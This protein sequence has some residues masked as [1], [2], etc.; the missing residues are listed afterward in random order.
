MRRRRL[1]RIL[2]LPL[3]LWFVAYATDA[4]GID[5]CPMHSALAYQTA[6]AM[7]GMPGMD[8]MALAHAE[9]VGRAP[10]NAPAPDVPAP[11]HCTC[12]GACC[13]CA[14]ATLP[15]SGRMPVSAVVVAF[16]AAPIPRRDTPAPQTPR[17]L[18]PPSNGPPA[19]RTA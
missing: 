2:A 11:I 19:H 7:P 16:R 14:M 17:F 3:C 15:A 1:N 13:G 8:G 5:A 18:L 4:G 6:A 9:Q 12:M 10:A